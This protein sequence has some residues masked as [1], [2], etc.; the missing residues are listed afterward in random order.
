MSKIDN[1]I[2]PTLHEFMDDFYKRYKDL[3]K[4]LDCLKL[5]TDI[6]PKYGVAVL[7]RGKNKAANLF[8]KWLISNGLPLITNNYL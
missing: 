2:D 6:I 1:N 8:A 5:K 4:E 3:M 7:N